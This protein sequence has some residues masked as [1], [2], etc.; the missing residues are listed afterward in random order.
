MRRWGYRL[1][2]L[3][4]LI[5][6]TVVVYIVRPHPLPN[7][8]PVKASA[9]DECWAAVRGGL[10]AL[11]TMREPTAAHEGERL[12]LT[13]AVTLATGD[14]ATYSCTLHRDAAGWVVDLAGTR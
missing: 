7:A 9:T 13:G 10:Q 3:A 6:A 5:L 11:T 14:R 1:G 2:A 12:V 8:S 4:L